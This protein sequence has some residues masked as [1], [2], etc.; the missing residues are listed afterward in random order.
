MSERPIYCI[1]TSAL[2]DLKRLYPT[3]VFPGLW[4]KLADLVA[5]RRLIAPREVLKEI[6][7]KD[8]VLLHWVKRHKSMFRP[9]SREQLEMAREIL[10]RFPSLVDQAKQI[11]DAD[12]F[13]IGLTRLKTREIQ[14]TL[15]GG[16]CIVVSHETS[17]AGKPRIPDVCRC[18]H[19]QCIR[20]EE[21]FRREKW[22]F[23]A[24]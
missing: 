1:D 24:R 9:Q 13:V 11:P 17:H 16:E 18:Y 21:L 19:T 14:R 6:E 4:D 12:P 20:V 5:E 2:I 22:R 10:S 23:F 3:D 7:K 15:F 8:D